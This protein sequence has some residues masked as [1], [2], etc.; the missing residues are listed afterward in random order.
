[1][2]SNYERIF[3]KLV[4]FESFVPGHLIRL[5]IHPFRR[6]TPHVATLTMKFMLLGQY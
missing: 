2:E 4:R 1:M 6:A 5:F 3:G